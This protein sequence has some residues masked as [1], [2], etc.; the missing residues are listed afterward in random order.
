MPHSKFNK[1]AKFHDLY[2]LLKNTQERI[3]KLE[4]DKL[5]LRSALNKDVVHL[6]TEYEQNLAGILQELKES[7]ANCSKL[8][9]EN[10]ELKEKIQAY[11]TSQ[12]RLSSRSSTSDIESKV[13]EELRRITNIL[14]N[15]LQ[16][17]SKLVER[18]HQLEDQIAIV[19]GDEIEADSYCHINKDIQELLLK[20]IILRRKV[21]H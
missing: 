9:I 15:E 13:M 20:L 16:E 14:N 8:Q 4:K 18:V 10:Q 5:Q 3:K 12:S 21:P 11:T 19:A 17:K 2:R 1:R 6:V 7:V